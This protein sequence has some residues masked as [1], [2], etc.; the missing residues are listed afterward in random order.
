MDL[1]KSSLKNLG[2]SRLRRVVVN[3]GSVPSSY[4]SRKKPCKAKL[5]GDDTYGTQVPAG[6]FNIDSSLANASLS[7]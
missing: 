2:A 3:P 5:N 6:S 1:S 4:E 7:L